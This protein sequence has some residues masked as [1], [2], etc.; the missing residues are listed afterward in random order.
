MDEL[1][2][3]LK[4][5]EQQMIE[6]IGGLVALQSVADASGAEECRK[7]LEQMA[8]YAARDGMDTFMHEKYCLSVMAGTGKKEIGVWNH[9]DVVPAE[10]NWT[11]PPFSMQMQNGYLIG[12]G[13][14]DNKGPAV[15]VYY[16]MRFCMEKGLLKNIRVRQILGNSEETGMDDVKYYVSQCQ[17]PDYSFVADS[18]FPVC[19]GEKGI[20]RVELETE[21]ILA[22]FICLEGGTVCNSVPEHA[23]AKLLLKGEEIELHAEGIG[24]HAAAP[25]H[26]RNAI[27]VLAGRMAELD[28]GEKERRVAVFLREAAADGYGEGLGIA[29]EDELSGRLTCN[30]GVLR[31]CEGHVKVVLDIRYP[32]TIKTDSFMTRLQEKAGQ[33]GFAVRTV[34]DDPPYYREKNDPFVEVL[35]EAWRKE[36][37]QDGEPYV[38]GGGTYARHIPNAVAFGPGMERDF[39]AAGLP[40]GHGNCHSADEAESVDNIRKAVRIY[41]RALAALNQ[42]VNMV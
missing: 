41:V 9:L 23:Q 38:M 15:A 19:C 25:D 26:T 28:L 21:D 34:H 10:G 24:G 8:A 16:A 37:G 14:Q 33:A 32:V 12:R 17:V 29:C 18:G 39:V 4:E 31:L 5:K 6:D 20:C 22:Q 42:W 2:V 35:M 13:V 36:T 11:H 27:G 40:E 3:W 1:N 7:V 30:T